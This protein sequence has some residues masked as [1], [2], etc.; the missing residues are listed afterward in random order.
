MVDVKIH[1]QNLFRMLIRYLWFAAFL[2]LNIHNIA[3]NSFEEYFLAIKSLRFEQ[4]KEIAINQFEGDLKEHLLQFTDVLID[5]VNMKYDINFLDNDQTNLRILKHLIF[6]YQNLYANNQTSIDAYASFS[7]ALNLSE[8]SEKNFL[9]KACLIAVLD[10]LKHEIFIGS[11]QFAP[12]LDHFRE[13]KS[14]DT[15][16][17]LLTLYEIVFYSKGDENL[18]VSYDY[19]NSI[20][21]LDVIFNKVKKSNPYYPF[22]FYEKGIQYKLS[23]NYG[24]SEQYFMKTDSISENK[25]HLGALNAANLWQLADLMQLNNDVVTAKKYLKQ[26]RQASKNLRDVFY[27]DRLSSRIFV[28]TGQYDSAFFYLDK[29]I[30]LEYTLGFKN[31]T[32]E[33]SLLAID[34]NTSKLKLDNLRL[35][36]KQK[37]NKNLLISAISLLF[38]GSIVAFLFQKNTVKKK[39]LAEQQQQIEIQKVETLLKEQELVSIDAMIEGQEKERTKVANELHDDLGSLMATVKLHFDN[40]NVD[41]KDP[42]L[43]NAQKLLEE[44][45]QKIRG[46]AHSKNSGVMANHGLLPAVKKM[47]KTISQTNALEINVEDFGLGERLENSL[48]LTIFR[49]LQELIAN[50]I[51]HAE[52]T[53]A[54]IQ[55]T[56]YEDN[57]N[58]IVEDNG[59]GF[60]MSAVKRNENGMGLGTIEKRVEYL[61]GT[62]TADSVLG[63]GTS[64]LIDIPI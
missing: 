62:F 50:I 21:K 34:N 27:D 56:Q 46:M 63:K 26:S 36:T 15:D 19:A 57:L 37:I 5:P 51:K 6:G 13:I 38:L 33:S 39:I 61:E 42:A 54:N 52:A 28:K 30:N 17:I 59:R 64:I 31:N 24:L 16:E 4:A 22:Y 45:Y 40:V 48:E 9:T 11:R 18:K 3:A 25:A 41:K 60:D 2:Y 20:A 32:L 35:E 44:A 29:S 43:K 58:I 14:D 10:L 23:G 55:F 1:S 8:Q 12:Y 49:I 53:K 7:K 47:A